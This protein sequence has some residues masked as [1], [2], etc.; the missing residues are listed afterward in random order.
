MAAYLE[1]AAHSAYDMFYKYFPLLGFWSGKFILIAPFP[2]RCP[3]VPFYTRDRNLCSSILS[4]DWLTLPIISENLL[5]FHRG[6]MSG[7]Y[8]VQILDKLVIRHFVLKFEPLRNTNK[9]HS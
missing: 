2:D 5:R 4:Q 8:L 7:N 1:I 9:Y 6:I 3:L